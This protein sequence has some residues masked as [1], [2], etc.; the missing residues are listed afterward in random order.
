V[1]Y[2]TP[3]FSGQRLVVASGG[4]ARVVEPGV[5]S[6]FAWTGSATWGPVELVGGQPGQDEVLVVHETATAGVEVHNVGAEPF[7]AYL[8]SGPDLH[9]EAAVLG[10]GWAR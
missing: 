10:S 8:F 3:R 4:S 7:T 6:V 9:P 5:Y 2:G 1:F